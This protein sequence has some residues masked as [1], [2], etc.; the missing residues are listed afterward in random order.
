M[1]I[2]FLQ[3]PVLT[4]ETETTTNNLPDLDQKQTETNLIHYG[5]LID[6][7]VIGS[8]DYD[9]RGT[10][11]EEGFLSGVSFV[12]NPVFALCRSE[13]NVAEDVARAYSKIL[14]EPKVVVKILDRSNRPLSVI[15][16]AVKT[17][18]RFNI[19]R[20][21]FLN[22]LIVTAGGITDKTSGEIQIFRPQKLNCLS[23]PVNEQAFDGNSGENRERFVKARQDDGSQYINIRISDLISGKTEA[24][25]QILSGDVITIL[26]AQP[27]YV[28]GGVASPKQIPIH[29][30]LTLSRAIS[31]AGGFSKEAKSK[32]ITIFRRENNETKI[33]EVDFDEIKADPSADVILQAFDIVE[34]RQSERQKRMFPP[35][36]KLAEKN[37]KNA[38]KLPLRIID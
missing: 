33:I 26:E 13:E 20:P 1:C 9:W 36:L 4:Q 5:D 27:V 38:E 23:Q 15:Y 18:Q 19:K 25:P 17:P 30:Q 37:E 14:R 2:I 31:S 24:N 28:I 7:D 32:K 10:I 12:E 3:S 16:G 35:V 6:V 11:D 34:V 21:V 22:E 29:S 8:F